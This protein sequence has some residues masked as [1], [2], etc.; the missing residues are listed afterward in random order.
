[1]SRIFA[2]PLMAL[3]SSQRH[4]G[5]A[6]AIVPPVT[7]TTDVMVICTKKILG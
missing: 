6:Q 3:P 5:G 7:C 4:K 1:M 2:S